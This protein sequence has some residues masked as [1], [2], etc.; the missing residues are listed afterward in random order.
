MS[1]TKP[2]ESSTRKTIDLI[3][4]NLGWVIDETEKNCNVFTE[5]AKT[6]KQ[7][8]KFKGKS[9]DYVLYKSQTDEPIAIIEAKRK[10]WNVDKALQ[11]GIEYAKLINVKIVF[12]FDGAFVKTYHIDDERELTIDGVAVTQL[13]SEK[14]INQF[15]SEGS[16]ITE[17]SQKTKHT[18]A[19]LINI[20]SW[21]NDLLRKEGLREGIERFTEFANLLFL[22]LISELE[23]EREQNGEPRILDPQYS[24]E[25]FADLKPTQMINYINNTVLPHLVDK[26][27]HS[28]DV[29]QTNLSIKNAST[30]S[31]IVEKLS[32]VNLMDADSDVKGDAFEYF[33]KNSVTV[34]NDL[35]EY[36]TPRHLVNLMVELIEPKFGEKVYDPTCGTGGFLISA[37]N[38]I[39]KRCAN[40]KDNY[41]ILKE[42]TIYGVELTNTAKIA[43]MN[44]IITGDGH[45]NI[46]QQDCLANPVDGKYDVV[47][48]NIPYGQSTD[49]GNYYPVLSE[50]ADC[51]FIQHIIKSLNDTGRAAVIVPEGF[52]FRSGADEKTR[53]YLIENFNLQ[54]VISLPVG[55]FLPYTSAKTNIILFEKSSKTKK[56]WFFDLQNDGF[57]LTTLRRPQP[58]NDIPELLTRWQERDNLPNDKLSWL[59]D[60]ETIRQNNYSMLTKKYKPRTQYES[61]FPQVP[62]SEI[63][64]ENKD[65]ITINDNEKYKRI[66]VKYH[67]QGVF[68]RDIVKGSTIKTKTQK[69]TVSEQLIVAEIDAKFGAFGVV[70]KELEGAIVSSHYFLFDL[71]KEKVLPEYFDY[72][73]R[74]GKYEELIQPYVR[75]T[76]NYAAIRPN[77][78]LK[79][80]F[81]LPSLDVQEKIAEEIRNQLRIITHAENTVTTLE[82][83][84]INKSFF[85]SDEE[86]KFTEVVD[87]NPRYNLTKQSKDYFVEMAAVDELHGEIQYFSK[88]KR[89]SSGYSRFKD[90]DIL[91]AKITP[92][93][94]NGKMTIVHGLGD[95]IGIGS[96]EFF[97]FSPKGVDAKWLYFYLKEP[98]LKERIIY[99][100]K[101]TTGRKRVPLDFF[102]DLEIPS[103]PIEKQIETVGEL[104]TYTKAKESLIEVISLAEKTIS[105]IVDDIFS[106]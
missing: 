27:N 21:A 59:V 88:K 74:F 23:I 36:F 98:R 16:D 69:L 25:A 44:M 46:K 90:G 85:N 96:T 101:G 53:E 22:K 58:K 97:V 86:I 71:D 52:L 17:V 99:S 87:L 6:V 41:R 93:T 26:Y 82:E 77:D 56:V 38:Y 55:S 43:K 81:P 75:G 33:L 49:F 40:T 12:G 57:E 32:Q 1:Y 3:L 29:F 28:G 2:L 66:T 42:D 51:V 7:N 15:I 50:Q 4:S 13:I 47:L 31:K 68:L 103:I 72:L 48:A 67:G 10:G 89:L 73:I 78:V 83:T 9:P 62:F 11:Q 64:Q 20:F 37:F 70:P 95:E 8:K 30:L 92:C 65:S 39:K 34:G 35:G 60:V 19:E 79:L 54:A 102:K 94:E 63:M 24:W 100:M 80:Q 14:R 45:T 61:S 106:P 105:Q 5:R 18:R 84:G 104:D 76:T 91:F